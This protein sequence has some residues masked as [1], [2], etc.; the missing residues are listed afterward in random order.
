LTP[1][2]TSYSGQQPL[3]PPTTQHIPQETVES[4]EPIL[5][6]AMGNKTPLEHDL[7]ARSQSLPSVLQDEEGDAVRGTNSNIP[8]SIELP[9]IV[10]A[11][12]LLNEQVVP[13]P[14]TAN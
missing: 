4:N 2:S 14:V 6:S 3:V 9:T 11:E 12:L 13:S 7:V 10:P 5:E 8:T 1:A